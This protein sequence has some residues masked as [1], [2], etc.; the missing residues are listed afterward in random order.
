MCL[1]GRGGEALQRNLERLHR[2]AEASRMRVSRP[3]LCES[4]SVQGYMGA[5]HRRRVWRWQLTAG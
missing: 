5:V 2:W 1:G 4:S 3:A